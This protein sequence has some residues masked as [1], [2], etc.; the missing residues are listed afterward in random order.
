MDH[1]TLQK[2]VKSDLATIATLEIGILS[3][4][5]LYGSLGGFI[6]KC[7]L[8]LV[9]INVCLQVVCHSIGLYIPSFSV[10]AVLF[11]WALT[12]G[13]SAFIVIFL[14]P[15]ILFAK[16]VKGRLKTEGFIKQ[17]WVQASCLYLVIY[18]LIYGAFTMIQKPVHFSVLDDP[19]GWSGFNF[20]FAELWSL[21]GSFLILSVFANIEVNRLGLGVV[22]DV[23]KTFVARIKNTTPTD[24][25]TSD[26]SGL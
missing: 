26:G 13:G 5:D 14:S 10:S 1:Q 19:N 20:M 8:L 17:K 3:A 23:V 21:L 4:A 15:M 11:M 25:N 24:T 2:A 7:S 9:C 6:L 16:L 22:F 12:L 18:S